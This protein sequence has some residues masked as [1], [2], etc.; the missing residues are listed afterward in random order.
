MIT[1]QIHT[2]PQRVEAA[3][4]MHWYAQGGYYRIDA[5]G[6]GQTEQEAKA[7]AESMLGQARAALNVA[8]ISVP[9][10]V[11]ATVPENADERA[12]NRT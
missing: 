5:V 9:N 12:D 11:P 7:S 8:M 2:T 4:E 3:A 10:R 6:F 1:Y